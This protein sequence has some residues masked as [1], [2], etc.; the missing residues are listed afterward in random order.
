MDLHTNGAMNRFKAFRRCSL[1]HEVFINEVP[2]F[3]APDHADVMCRCLQGTCKY[4]LVMEVP[5]G[6][7]DNGTAICGYVCM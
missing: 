7:D 5:P 6:E 4:G 2:F 1:V 3:C